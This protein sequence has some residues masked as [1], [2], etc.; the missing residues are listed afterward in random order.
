MSV[1]GFCRQ[2][3]VSAA[4]FYGWRQR[5]A[6]ERRQDEPAEVSF[7]PLPLGQGMPGGAAEFSLQLPNGVQVTVPRD[8]D[9]ATLGRLLHLAGAME[10][11]DA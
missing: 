4:S 8:F 2:H 6:D 9:E 7:V 3:D 5:L 1:A 10:P 11:R